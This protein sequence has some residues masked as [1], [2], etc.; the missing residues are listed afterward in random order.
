LHPCVTGG[1]RPY[2]AGPRPRLRLVDSQ[3][4]G[5]DAIL[6]TYVPA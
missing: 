6:L 5:D 1:G 4:I 3:R 2:F